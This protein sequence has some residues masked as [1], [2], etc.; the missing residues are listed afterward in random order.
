MGYMHVD[1]LAK[2]M[3]TLR[4][5]T[6]GAAAAADMWLRG[7]PPLSGAQVDDQYGRLAHY[8]HWDRM[9]FIFAS[10]QLGPGS[11]LSPTAYSACMVPY[12]LGLPS[13]RDTCL[14]L[15]VRDVD[16]LWG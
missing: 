9:P 3:I 12:N 10:G 16:E 14:I 15:N 5:P 1:T 2:L 8:T 11:W 7:E 6:R 13:P 4:L